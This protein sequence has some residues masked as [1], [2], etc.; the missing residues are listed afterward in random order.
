M[1]QVMVAKG[2]HERGTSM[3]RLAKP[4]GVSDGTVRY[5]L[6]R[7]ERGG[8]DGRSNQPTAVDGYE[9][10]IA[11]IQERLGDARLTGRGR[12]VAARQIYEL[13]VRDH[14]YGGSERAVMR[15]LNRLS[16]VPKERAIRRVETPP[17][18]QAQLDWFEVRAPIGGRRREL[19]VRIGTLSHSRAR[20]TDVEASS[21]WPSA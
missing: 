6:K 2:L 1:E 8:A 12:P 14:G 10:A 21:P 4:L 18:V 7:L 11:A 13:L 16:G 5:R 17:G 9:A 15:H 20:L 3:R 19:Q